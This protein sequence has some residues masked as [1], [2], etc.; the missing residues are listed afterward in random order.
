MTNKI[1]IFQ[2]KE[3]QETQENNI[4]CTQKEVTQ[5]NWQFI[6]QLKKNCFKSNNMVLKYKYTDFGRNK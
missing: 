4:S 1:D 3:S 2:E 5:K 6:K